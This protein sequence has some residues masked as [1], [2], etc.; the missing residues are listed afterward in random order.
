MRYILKQ[1]Y[2]ALLSMAVISALSIAYGFF[3]LRA[4]T[5][6]Y[7]YT[8]NFWVGAIIILTG[9]GML[10]TPT[11]LLIRK[12]KLLDHSTYGQRYMEER[13]KKRTRAYEFLYI[14]MAIITVTAVVELIVFYV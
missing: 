9:L 14:G 10:L 3:T 12:S 8:A 13:E 1:L 4:F 6:A 2:T 5:L 7:I 11:H